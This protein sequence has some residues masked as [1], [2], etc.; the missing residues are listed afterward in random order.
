VPPVETD[1]TDN[2]ARSGLGV[3][4]VTNPSSG[5][6]NGGRADDDTT[7]GQMRWPQTGQG[8]LPSCT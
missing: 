5:P 2:S 3:R 4:L 7:G 6:G 8:L 1:G